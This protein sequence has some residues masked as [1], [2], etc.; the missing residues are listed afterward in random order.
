MI[1]K[2]SVETKSAFIKI[3]IWIFRQF[4]FIYFC[5]EL[6]AA[7]KDIQH[8]TH[9]CLQNSVCFI[10]SVSIQVGCNVFTTIKN[11]YSIDSI[12]WIDIMIW[13]DFISFGPPKMSDLID[14][15]GILSSVIWFDMIWFGHRPKWFDLILLRTLLIL[16]ITDRRSF[17]DNTLP[18][19]EQIS[20]CYRGV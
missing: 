15:G 2:V 12:D 16:S 20:F 7:H 17:W 14:L 11:N 1:E 13:F 4:H 9:S 19:K 8:E 3:K 18:V 5:C 10:Y 6:Q